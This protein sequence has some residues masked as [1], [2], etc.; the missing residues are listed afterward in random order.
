M[1]RRLVPSYYLKISLWFGKILFFIKP[2]PWQVYGGVSASSQ[3]STQVSP[4]SCYKQNNV[5]HYIGGSP[6]LVSVQLCDQYPLQSLDFQCEECVFVFKVTQHY[7]GQRVGVDWVINSYIACM[8]H[9]YV[10]HLL[11]HTC[12]VTI[13]RC[14][15]QHMQCFYCMGG[16]IVLIYISV[17]THLI[18]SLGNT[19]ECGIYAWEHGGR[20]GW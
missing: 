5:S 13:D 9:V 10:L 15:L 3:H 19:S 20:E 6:P 17:Y 14:R 11:I 16:S 4:P 18:L 12:N 8:P 1:W 2:L 7:L